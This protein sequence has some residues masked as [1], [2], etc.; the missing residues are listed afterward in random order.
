MVFQLTFRTVVIFF[1]LLLLMRLLGKRQ[2]GELELSELVVS[3][4]V[5]DVSAIPLQ[6]T[7]LPIWHGIVPAVTLFLCELGMSWLT[8]KSV[9]LR[10]IICGKPCFLIIEG[11][12]QQQAMRVCRLTVDELMEELRSR[13][14][15]DPATVKYAVLETDGLL[16][17]IVYP[18]QRP[19][20]PQQ[21]GLQ[22]EDDGYATVLI[23]DGRLLRA[24]LSLV[25]WDD[26]HLARELKKQGC[27]STAEVY[28]MIL[29]KTGKIYFQKKT[30]GTADRP[31]SRSV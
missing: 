11:M 12:I 27:G 17:V 13:D 31:P 24:N 9:S 28:A 2:M 23:E 14:V 8:M 5:A 6:D 4:L 3:I 18:D 10:R 7:S 26:A 29:Y 22:C 1:T 15:T 19:V 25:G 21:L 20:T 30:A 16:N